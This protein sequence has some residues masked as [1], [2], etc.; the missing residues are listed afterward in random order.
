MR[1]TIILALATAIVGIGCSSN[2]P[3]SVQ[4]TGNETQAV[5]SLR[6]NLS[7]GDDVPVLGK[8]TIT[9]GNGQVGNV[10]HIW[11]TI[12][13]VQIHTSD[14]GWFTAATPNKSFDF[15]ELV[16]GLTA[17]LDLYALPAGHYTQIRL[18]LADGG[19]LD[20]EENE[21][22]GNTIVV[23]GESFPL[24]IPSAYKTGIKCVR[25]FFIEEDETTEICLAFDVLK[26]VHYSAGNGYMMNPAYRTFKCDGSGDDVTESVDEETVEP[27][28]PSSDQTPE[29]T[30]PIDQLETVE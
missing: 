16:N 23:D 8:R 15:F 22:A 25:S 3:V 26:A 29:E 6:L 7:N 30:A 10:E 1:K 21:V 24:V 27:E 19:Y 9:K 11:L 12:K 14:S 2:Q 4:N 18:I 17:P 20:D 13:K 28:A 5:A